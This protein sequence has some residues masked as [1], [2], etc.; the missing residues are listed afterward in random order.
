MWDK[1]KCKHHCEV[2]ARESIQINLKRNW[3]WLVSFGNTQWGKVKP[4][5]EINARELLINLRRNWPWLVFGA[6]LVGLVGL[7]GHNKKLSRPSPPW[8]PESA[9]DLLNA[10][11]IITMK[12]LLKIRSYSFLAF[13][14][15]RRFPQ[16]IYCALRSC[17]NLW[18]VQFVKVKSSNTQHLVIQIWI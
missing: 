16:R 12:F 13:W 2:N 3:R 9:P 18:L 6:G 7:L 17:Q 8:P 1:N 5:C 14:E 4:H 11:I 10:N 15:I